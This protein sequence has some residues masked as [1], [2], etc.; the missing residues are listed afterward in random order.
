MSECVR[1]PTSKRRARRSEPNWPRPAFLEIV[2]ICVCVSFFGAGREPG[3]PKPC[4]GRMDFDGDETMAR[5]NGV[6]GVELFAVLIEA[7][8]NQLEFT[9]FESD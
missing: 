3:G 5:A 1:I 9:I 2:F 6:S 8:A 4:R 7:L